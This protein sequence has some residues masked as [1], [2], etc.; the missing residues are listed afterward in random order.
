MS[1]ISKGLLR[2]FIIR[3]SDVGLDCGH[4]IFGDSEYR[5]MQN[6]II[7]LYEYHAII[8]EEMTTCMK[9]KIRENIHSYR[10][11]MR[12]QILDESSDVP[13]KIRNLYSGSS[14]PSLYI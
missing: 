14:F 13:E 1:Q 12:A 2:S 11:S 8:P 5:V 10:D 6:A 7:H 3:C 4:V 9:L